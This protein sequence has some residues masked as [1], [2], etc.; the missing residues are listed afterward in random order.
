MLNLGKAEDDQVWDAPLFTTRLANFSGRRHGL[1]HPCG[2]RKTAK[3]VS[4]VK[5]RSPRA[6]EQTKQ[7][8][9]SPSRLPGSTVE[10]WPLLGAVE[11]RPDSLRDMVCGR[12]NWHNLER[13]K[14]NPTAFFHTNTTDEHCIVQTV[15]NLASVERHVAGFEARMFPFLFCFIDLADVHN[16]EHMGGL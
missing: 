14:K 13:L 3:I 5:N 9:A 12:N 16:N 10:T 11:D 1:V 2:Q 4:Q 6:H 8:R 15:I 7:T